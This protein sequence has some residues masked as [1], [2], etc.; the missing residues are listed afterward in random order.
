MTDEITIIPRPAHIIRRPGG[1]MLTAHTAV[2]AHPEAA[3]AVELLRELLRGSTG[4]SFP[5]AVDAVAGTIVFRLDPA[6]GLGAEG[7][8]ISVCD[9]RIT[10]VAAE[11]AGLLHAVQ[12]L[13][14][15]LPVEVFRARPTGATR[16]A[17]PGVEIEDRPSLPWRGAM[18]DVARWYLPP[19][20]LHRMVDLLA[21]H[22]MT[23]LH[24]HLTDDQGW[25]FPV[26]AYPLLTEVGGWRAES[27]R[28]HEFQNTFDGTP[29]G[30]YYTKRELR[31]LVEHGRT[32]GVTIVPE[33]DLPGH[34]QSAIAAYPR[35]GNN[36]ERPVTVSTRWGIVRD[37]LNVEPA[38][39]AF[40]RDVFDEVLDIFPSEYV[41]LGG[42]ECPKDQ[43]NSSSRARERMRELGL[44]DAD[45]L[46]S[47]FVGQIAAHLVQRGRRQIGWDEILQGGLPEGATV[48]SWQGEEGGIAAANAGHDAI[49]CPSDVTYFDYYQGDP[50]TEP[51]AATGG[52][53]TV[54]DVYRYRPI[55][56]ELSPAAR[57]HILGVQGQLW[58]EY[59]PTPQH[60]EYMAFPR[61][62]ALS[63]VAWGTAGDMEEFTRRLQPHLR[64][65]REAG[66]TLRPAGAP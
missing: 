33:I 31:A 40:C 24:L 14:Q 43:W 39:I 9:E 2:V 25:R 26:E 19:A 55:P 11:I 21:M 44:A 27:I 5:P 63:E 54:A 64:R 22:R 53:T 28:G 29:H 48:M 45:S 30:G 8:R 47:W 46:Q 65:L 34:M 20:F 36:P 16:W 58:T 38:T 51:L 7:Y 32:R 17:V 41:H 59:M 35:L 4:F 1:V 60:V 15:L 37:V 50:A 3:P 61:M 57:G 13:R 6:T 10:L 49:M 23:V 18:V 52:I 42:D 12:T 56:A 66:L 62:S